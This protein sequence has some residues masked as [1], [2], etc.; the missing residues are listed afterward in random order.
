MSDERRAECFGDGTGGR[1]H[2]I[3]QNLVRE[4]RR[5]VAHLKRNGSADTL[6]ADAESRGWKTVPLLRHVAE[7]CR[8]QP[9][10]AHK[11]LLAVKERYEELC[12][13]R[14]LVLEDRKVLALHARTEPYRDIWDRFSAVIDDYD[15]C[16]VLLDAHHVATAI[17]GTVLYTGDYRHIIVNGSSFFRK[18]ASTMSGTWATGWADGRRREGTVGGFSYLREIRPEET[19][20]IL[21]VEE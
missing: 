18:P 7:L 5:A 2:T 20:S 10:A 1:C 12:R 16:E 6:L 8:E 15:D 19:V 3:Q 9:A 13:R 4:F 14:R 11:T 17:D 21:A